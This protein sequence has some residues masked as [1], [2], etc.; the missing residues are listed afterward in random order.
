MTRRKSSKK[1]FTKEI[2]TNKDGAD[3]VLTQLKE[4][5]EETKQENKATCQWTTLNGTKCKNAASF[6]INLIE[7][8]K[9]LKIL[10]VPAS[11]ES[12]C[13]LCSTHLMICLGLGGLGIAHWLWKR[14]LNEQDKLVYQ[15][16]MAAM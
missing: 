7:N 10:P 6:H 1:K 3:L 15:G 16:G 14:T 8:G 4:E 5:E 9:A 11:I 13:S 12:C 2:I